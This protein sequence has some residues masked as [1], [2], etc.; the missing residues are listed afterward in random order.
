MRKIK[1][2]PAPHTEVV[3]YVSDRMKEDMETCHRCAHSGDGADC[4][5]CEWADVMA[6]DTPLC[7]V[8]E[9]IDKVLGKEE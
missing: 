5:S 3:V 6:W 4:N 9:V 1:I 7:T 8:Q 2:F